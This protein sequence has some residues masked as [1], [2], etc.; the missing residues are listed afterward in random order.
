[1]DQSFAIKSK[2]LVKIR[3]SISKEIKNNDKKEDNDI[4]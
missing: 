1:M 4:Y 3:N 2:I